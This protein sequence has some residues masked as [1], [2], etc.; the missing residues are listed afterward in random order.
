MEG[1]GGEREEK[2]NGRGRGGRKAGEGKRESQGEGG[3]RGGRKASNKEK[4]ESKNRYP[5]R[6]RM[7][8]AHTELG[9]ADGPSAPVLSAT[10][11][12]PTACHHHAFLQQPHM[13][14]PNLSNYMANVLTPEL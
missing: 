5:S 7:Q 14:F 6:T 10:H 2:G 9:A 11:L 1:K 3:R 4:Q 8:T 13:P 12:P